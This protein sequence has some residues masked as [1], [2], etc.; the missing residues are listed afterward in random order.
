[1]RVL[2]ASSEIYPLAKTGGLADVAG[3]LPAAL[4][5]HGAD[6]RLLMPAYR[7]IAAK[8]DAKP[9]ANLGDPFGRGDAVILEGRMPDSGLTVWLID[10]PALYDRDGGPYQDGHGH[11][12]PDNDIRFALLGWV[13]AR[14]SQ[15]N[16]PLGWKPDIIH[17]HDWQAGLAPAYLQAWG[18]PR[19]GT[20][21]TIHNMAYQGGFAKEVLPSLGLPWSFF[22]M[23]GLEFW[24]RLS[25]LKAGLAY[26]D[27]LTTV[28]PSYAHEI[29]S[30]PNGFGMEGLLAWRTKD[31]SGILNGADYSIWNPATDP[32]IAHHFT[33]D[34]VTAGKAANKAALQAELGLPQIADAPLMIVVSRLSDQKGMDLLLNIL[35]ALL[36]QG[37]QLA[38]LGTGEKWLE[39]ALRTLSQK[40]PDQVAARIGFSEQMAHRLVAG[41]DMLMMPSRFEPCGLTQIYAMRYGTLPV[42]HRT[43]GLADTVTDATYDSLL[44]GSATGFVFDQATAPAFQWC[45]ERAI[46]LYRHPEQWRR[47]QARAVQMDFTWD[48]AATQYLALYNEIEPGIRLRGPSRT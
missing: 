6:L 30:A 47:I 41:G 45:A 34:Q 37:A 26:S 5:K 15:G 39:D 43:G 18:G 22:T 1:M 3:A 46:A 13:A 32:H 33:P 40:R 42:V 25:Y 44:N 23:N 36:S 11:D 29:Q 10:S 38:L 21:F 48:K 14:L 31:L 35:P 9:I 28:S 12:W 2:F 8:T 4:A 17:A 19:P 16:S 24:D 7:G 27:R 20:V